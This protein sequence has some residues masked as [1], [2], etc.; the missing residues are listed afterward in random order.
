MKP[1]EEERITRWIDGELPDSEVEDLLA[2]HPELREAKSQ[3]EAL[4]NLLRKELDTGEKIPYADFFN[5]QLLKRIEE[6]T[7]A[8]ASTA[9]EREALAESM[10]PRFT[11]FKKFAAFAAIGVAAVFAILFFVNVQVGGSEI[12]STYTPDPRLEATSFYS[13][14]AN[15]TVLLIEGLEEIP[16]QREVTGV[17]AVGYIPQDNRSHFTLDS[18][19]GQP[20]LVLALDQARRPH[21][22]ELHF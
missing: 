22:R 14:E 16:A 17:Q 21:V 1:E 10:F 12:V 8:P 13:D 20:L 11:F 19:A 18:A 15:A 5:H 4:G 3:S 9:A 6:E 7:E 2:A